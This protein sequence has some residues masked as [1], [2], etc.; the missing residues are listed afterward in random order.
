[1]A[2][3]PLNGT[4]PMGRNRLHPKAN[5]SGGCALHRSHVLRR[6]NFARRLRPLRC[7]R[8]E[9]RCNSA[10]PTARPARCNAE[11]CW[12]VRCSAAR[13]NSANCSAVSWNWARYSAAHC[14]PPM[15]QLAGWYP[16]RRTSATR[17]R[18]PARA[19]CSAWPD[20]VRRASH[21]PRNAP[22]PEPNSARPAL[23]NVSSRRRL[24]RCWAPP[25]LGRRAPWRRI[26]RAA[27]CRPHCRPTASRPPPL[28]PH[29]RRRAWRLPGLRAAGRT[30]CV[31]PRWAAD[32]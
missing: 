27:Y 8:R 14:I 17:C 2:R 11:R 24:L 32:A 19:A 23:R 5:S 3:P 12:T 10:L 25:P 20:S 13:C 30:E 9:A 26:P 28:E 16:V 18:P 1:M 22:P 31:A 15:E 29:C 6:R 7:C 21:S 4:G